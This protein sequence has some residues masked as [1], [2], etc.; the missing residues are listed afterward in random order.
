MSRARTPRKLLT[1]MVLLAL[2]GGLAAL[3]GCSSRGESQE[4]SPAGNSPGM[5]DYDDGLIHH[6]PPSYLFDDMR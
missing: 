3:G 5:T 2:G 1:T 4:G 6:D